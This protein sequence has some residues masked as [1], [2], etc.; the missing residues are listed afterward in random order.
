MRKE[1]Y[2]DA[3]EVATKAAEDAVT[4]LSKAIHEKGNASWV[5]AGGSSPLQAYKVLA[6]KH[7][8]AID[9]AKVTIAIGDERCVPLDHAD[10]NWGQIS[11]LLFADER[12]AAAKQLVPGAEQGAEKGAELYSDLLRQHLVD[13]E[14]NFGIDLLWLGVGEDGHTLS[15]FPGNPALE[16]ATGI[17]IP[18]H[19]SPKPPADRITLSLGTAAMASKIVIFA[20]GAAKR[21]ALARVEQSPES[22]PIGLLAQRADQAGADV[23]WLYDEAAKIFVA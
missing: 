22:L 16:D 7:S 4:T 20:A 9:W 14:G 13:K 17:I 18:V 1:V 5:L 6:D 10:S 12:I 19:D 15:L 21:E 3:G 23:L 2:V 8:H 11:K